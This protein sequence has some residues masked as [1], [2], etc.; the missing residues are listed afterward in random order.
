MFSGKKTL[1]L[2]LNI[3][4]LFFGAEDSQ[5]NYIST[6]FALVRIFSDYLPFYHPLTLSLSLSLSLCLSTYKST[7]IHILCFCF[8]ISY[9]LRLSFSFFL[10]MS[11]SQNKEA[12]NSVHRDQQKG[13]LYTLEWFLSKLDT[14][15]IEYDIVL[16]L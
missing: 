12:R 10:S 9:S 11:F 13:N 7:H 5:K 6:S 14:K 16:M 2:T 1:F 3:L 8:T 4:Q 15:H